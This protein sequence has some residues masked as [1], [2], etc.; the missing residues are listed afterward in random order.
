MK[1][2]LD[3]TKILQKNISI[4]LKK[5]DS[6]DL[7]L[8]K[9]RLRRYN[10]TI[11]QYKNLQKTNNNSCAICLKTDCEL[12]IDHDH[13]CCNY[14]QK[15]NAC[16]IRGLLCPS[17]NSGLGKFKDSLELLNKAIA[18]LKRDRV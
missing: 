5:R 9:I 4:K 2:T 18:Y 11:E 3:I 16:C 8:L 10:L 12:Y 17:C 15:A 13:A 6:Y 7:K 1:N 14:K